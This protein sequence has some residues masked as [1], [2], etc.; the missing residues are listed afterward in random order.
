MSHVLVA[1]GL[2]ALARQMME[3]GIDPYEPR[4]LAALDKLVSQGNF[5]LPSDGRAGGIELIDV[6]R[7]MYLQQV[8]HTR[9]SAS[10]ELVATLPGFSREEVRDTADVMSALIDGAKSSVLL[11]AYRL[12]DEQ[13]ITSLHDYHRKP[14]ASLKLI[15]SHEEDLD[16][17]MDEWP[18]DARPQHVNAAQYVERV[19]LE[20][21]RGPGKRSYPLFHAK[22]IVVDQRHCYV[23]SANFTRGGMER[24][25]EIGLRVESEEVARGIWQLA[26]SF[27]RG[28]FRYVS[29]TPSS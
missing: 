2:E 27:P 11:L 28:L 24:N 25:V 3:E 14:G 20:I 9:L 1:R 22:T 29:H 12:T 10:I 26:E 5:H 6:M 23:G 17:L 8:E 16:Q 13:I 18:A 7:A 15:V 21:D 4:A 19:D